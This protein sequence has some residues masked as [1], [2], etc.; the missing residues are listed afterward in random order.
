MFFCNLPNLCLRTFQVGTAFLEIC[1]TTEPWVCFSNTSPISPSSPNLLLLALP[2]DVSLYTEWFPQLS[3][4][5]PIFSPPQCRL[6]SRTSS[7]FSMDMVNFKDVKLDAPVSRM[8]A[9]ACSR[10]ASQDI[11]TPQ[12]R[13]SFLFNIF[14]PFDI[15]GSSPSIV[16]LISSFD[17]NSFLVQTRSTGSPD[18]TQSSPCARHFI[19]SGDDRTERVK[20]YQL[21]NRVWPSFLKLSFANFERRPWSH[22]CSCEALHTYCCPQLSSSPPHT[23]PRFSR[24]ALEPKRRLERRRTPSMLSFWD[25][26]WCVQSV[27][28]VP[29]LAELQ[30]TTLGCLIL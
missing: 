9:S 24:V 27:P 14:T 29:Q 11:P 16:V 28:A 10:S 4:T 21:R 5:F 20:P 1:A 22:T 2:C 30:Q 15:P 18:T 3:P 19:F 23:A 6:L 12:C 8:I 13:Q 25:Y 26:S 7:L 17:S